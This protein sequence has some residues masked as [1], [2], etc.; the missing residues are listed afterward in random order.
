ML[1]SNEVL[2]AIVSA[3]ITA[4]IG[5][6]VVNFIK[7]KTEKRLLK[8]D[9]IKESLE[10]NKQIQYKI[11]TISKEYKADRIWIAQF[12]NGG[13]FYPTGK[14]IQKFSIC[15]ELI[16][17][18]TV[19]SVQHTLSNIPI[20]LFSKGLNQ[21]LENDRILIPDVENKNTDAFGLRY[22]AE[23]NNCKSKYIFAIKSIDDKFIGILSIDY[24]INKIELTTDEI[25]YLM[26]EVSSIGG[27]LMSYLSDK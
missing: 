1:L 18:D 14:S 15:Y 2:V 7:I 21:L 19:A 20:S 11:E 17:D 8:K 23:Q 12:H 5:P 27:V 26:V 6:I 13:Y 25:N 3:G 22:L 4:V 24:V 16:N 10:I 9:Q